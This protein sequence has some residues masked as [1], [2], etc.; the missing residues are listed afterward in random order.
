MCRICEA[1]LPQPPGASFCSA[2]TVCLRCHLIWKPS[3]VWLCIRVGSSGTGGGPQS[4]S[5]IRAHS[6]AT[7]ISKYKL[8]Y[9]PCPLRAWYGP[10]RS[11]RGR[12]DVM[13][14]IAGLTC[15]L[16]LAAQRVG[17]LG[18]GQPER[19]QFYAGSLA[20]ISRNCRKPCKGFPWWL[21]EGWGIHLEA[22]FV[23]SC[24]R[25]WKISQSFYKF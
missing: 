3:L 7:S 18:G 9:H 12:E 4:P 14:G 8:A 16:C 23:I 2:L 24:L 6:C 5:E 17:R 1:G 10:G 11:G 13:A 15:L 19:K 21:E 25:T 20:S 22:C